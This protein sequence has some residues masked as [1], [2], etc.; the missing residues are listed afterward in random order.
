MIRELKNLARKKYFH[1]VLTFSIIIIFLFILGV[2][3]LKYNVEGETNMPFKLTKIS[4]ISSCEG[5]DVETQEDTR[6][7][8]DVYQSNDIYLYID[9]NDEYKDTKAIEYITI[10]NI[11]I[12]GNKK[13]QI[14]I[15][16]PDANDE[17]Q[18]FKNVPEN[19]VQDLTYEGAM[20]SI[21]KQLRIG[22]QMTI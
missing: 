18:L 17:N 6:W 10:D 11:R 3:I 2:M 5:I 14:K 20:E 7:A 1:I 21:F 8:F 19:V 16:K 9:K 12:D 15:Y 4:V 22:V 13:D